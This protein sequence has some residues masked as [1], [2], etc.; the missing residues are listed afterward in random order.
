MDPD[1]REALVAREPVVGNWISLAHPA[2]AET[3]AGLDFDFVVVD[4]EHTSISVDEL[5]SMIR[6]TDAGDGGTAPIVRLPDHDPGRIKR[7][8]DMGAAGL[9][10]PMVETAEEAERIVEAMRYPPEGRRGAAPARASGYGRT[11]GEYFESA[12]EGIATIVQIE[13]ERAVENI[14]GIL[15]VDGVDAIQ[16]G[17]GDLSASVGAFGEWEDDAFRDAL[18]RAVETADEAGVPVGMLALDAEG[19]DRWLDAGVDF[20]TVGVD[21]AYLQDGAREAKA[22]FEDAVG[23]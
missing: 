15:A 22:H 5:E 16:I 7:A 3:S 6:A 4:T 10:F 8:L 11:F 23:Q 18:S 21:V 14:E 13:T 1:F 12:D 9:M 19:I 20:M 2:I 17:Q